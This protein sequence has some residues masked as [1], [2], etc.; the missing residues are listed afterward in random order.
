MAYRDKQ[1]HRTLHDLGNLDLWGPRARVLTYA[2][3]D[4][5]KGRRDFKAALAALAPPGSHATPRVIARAVRLGGEDGLPDRPARW[6]LG[7]EPRGFVPVATL[8]HGVE[9]GGKKGPGA[10]GHGLP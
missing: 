7:R 2:Q 10:H 5:T 4:C 3:H 8:Q 1:S 9:A 6:P